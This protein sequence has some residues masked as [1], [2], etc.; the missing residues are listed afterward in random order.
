MDANSLPLMMYVQAF[1]FCSASERRVAK[2][3]NDPNAVTLI[4]PNVTFDKSL[5]IK[6]GGG[7]D[8]LSSWRFRNTGIGATAGL[9]NEISALY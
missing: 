5:T 4:L 8:R 3:V 2:R 7:E 6:L 1:P 9:R